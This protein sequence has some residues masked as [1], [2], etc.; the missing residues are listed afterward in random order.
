LNEFGIAFHDAKLQLINFGRNVP[1]QL[2]IKD[3]IHNNLPS[4]I[5]LIT[6]VSI[7]IRNVQTYYFFLHRVLLCL[8]NYCLVEVSIGCKRATTRH[9]NS[10]CPRKCHPEETVWRTC[11]INRVVSKVFRL[12]ERGGIYVRISDNPQC[13]KRQ[14]IV[15]DLLLISQILM[16]LLV[17]N[18]VVTTPQD[19]KSA[20]GRPEARPHLAHIA[21]TR[22]STSM[23]QQK[24]TQGRLELPTFSVLD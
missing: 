21:K 17:Q 8:P 12:C 1:V 24:V 10:I 9:I 3:K 2:H 15:L 18:E 11:C 19:Q 5:S 14:V 7:T 6:T 23:M 20:R 13:S 16:F 22:P 4:N